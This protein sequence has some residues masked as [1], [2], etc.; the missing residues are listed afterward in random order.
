MEKRY[1][2]NIFT[3]NFDY[4][5]TLK[6]MVKDCG[7]SARI[8]ESGH[9]HAPLLAF[10]KEQAEA[11]LKE[12]GPDVCHTEIVKIAENKSGMPNV[13]SHASL[14]GKDSGN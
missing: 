4:G 7:N 11:A 14:E 6:N 2:T 5:F 3:R 12:L 8:I 13:L 1:P 10:A 9:S